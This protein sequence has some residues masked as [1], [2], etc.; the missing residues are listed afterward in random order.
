MMPTSPQGGPPGGL[1]N[2]QRGTVGG[3][4]GE[5]A[6]AEVSL[7]QTG[8]SRQATEKNDDSIP[9]RKSPSQDR[10]GRDAAR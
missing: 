9:S 7:H 5:Y 4:G 10:E 3:L 2:K 1:V 8:I 6:L